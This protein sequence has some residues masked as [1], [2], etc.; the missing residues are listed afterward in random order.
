MQV[1]ESGKI[2]HRGDYVKHKIGKAKRFPSA[3]FQY[4]RILILL[5]VLTLLMAVIAV[6][7]YIDYQEHGMCDYYHEHYLYIW[8]EE[9]YGPTYEYYNYSYLGGYIGDATGYVYAN[10]SPPSKASGCGG[11]NMSYYGIYPLWNY[12]CAHIGACYCHVE[13]WPHLSAMFSPFGGYI[14]I[15]P[16][17]EVTLLPVNSVAQLV[18]R[19]N[20]VP[21]GTG[22]SYIIPIQFPNNTYTTTSASPQAT[23]VIAGNATG[24]RH[25]ILDSNNEQ[26]QVWNRDHTSN[27]DPSTYG[28]PVPAIGQDRHFHVRG[29]GTLELRNITL[30]RSEAWVEDNPTAVS[31]GVAVSGLLGGWHSH[32]IMNHENATI[33]RSRANMPEHTGGSAAGGVG[34]GGYARFTMYNGNIY[35]NITASHQAGGIF[36][37]SMAIGIPQRRVIAVIHDGIIRD[38]YSYGNG[39]GIGACCNTETHI[40]GGAI[41]GNTAHYYGLWRQGVRTRNRCKLCY[42]WRRDLS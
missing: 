2:L 34:L 13:Y 24:G 19:I 33:S 26:N 25:I 22:N 32:F 9:H 11:T 39:G 7:A 17:S 28:L 31:G 16:L 15:A 3:G 23:I 10:N 41:Y 6:F 12:D 36:L 40:H 1:L 30:T 35:Y 8:T 29:G 21:F 38:N 37:D 18:T 20:E 27:P 4:W 14:G 5:N 42:D